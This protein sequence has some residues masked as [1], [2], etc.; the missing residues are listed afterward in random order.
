MGTVA[1]PCLQGTPGFRR[2]SFTSRSFPGSPPPAPPPD[3]LSEEGEATV[4][5]AASASHSRYRCRRCRRSVCG[6]LWGGPARSGSLPVLGC[7]LPGHH[8]GT[9]QQPGPA[10]AGGPRA[11]GQPARV[12][13]AAGVSPR[14]QVPLPEAAP[15]P[16]VQATSR[17]RP[18]VRPPPVT[19]TSR[20]E[21]GTPPRPPTRLRN[22]APRAQET[23]CREE[24]R[25]TT[26]LDTRTETGGRTICE[27]VPGTRPQ[28]PGKESCEEPQL[29]GIV[30]KLF[31]RQGFYLQVN[32]DGS[33]QGTPEDTSSF[34]HFNLIP[35]EL[36]VVTTQSANLGNYMAMNAE[37][38]LYS[39]PHFT[40]ECRF[41]EC[42]FENY[43]VLYAS[44][45][46]HQRRSGRAWYMGL[47]KEGRVMK[48]NRVKKTKAAAHFVPKLLEVAVYQE[49][50]LH[51]VPETSPSSP[52]ARCHVVPGLEAPCT[53]HHHSLSP[54][55]A[56]GPALTPAATLMP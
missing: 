38:L 32:P 24:V 10:E 9:G 13:A 25:H 49:P 21:L 18:S 1:T 20:R 50:S 30:T 54:S 52:S 14:H 28:A 8:G 56:S 44:A 37:G 45:L 16:A 29:K 40:A 46:Y 5:A 35:A 17:V 23:L 19:C 2:P 27:G 6:L 31:C 48:G 47:D 4:A 26:R 53:R 51:S 36:R 33:I 15:H 55:P 11:R 7:L 43:Y 3:R 41:K 22:R 42:V 39:L 12:G 34:T